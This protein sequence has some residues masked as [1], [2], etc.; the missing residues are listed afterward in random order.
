MG[1]VRLTQS[2]IERIVNALSQGCSNKSAIALAG[3]SESTFY[4]WMSRGREDQAREIQSIYAELLEKVEEAEAARERSLVQ[5]ILQD[6]SWKSKA[7]LL[8]RLYP[9]R[10]GAVEK[11]D[12]TLRQAGAQQPAINLSVLTSEEKQQLNEMLEKALSK[13]DLGSQEP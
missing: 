2:V 10:W 4:L 9:D 1:Y 8:E 7:W 6:T 12:I 3:C 13:E 5:G 11:R